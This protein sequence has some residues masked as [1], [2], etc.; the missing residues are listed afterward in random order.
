MDENYF[1]KVGQK[2]RHLRKVKGLSQ[3]E[4]GELLD[5]SSR[6]IQKYE[7]GEIE[8]S[9]SVVNKLAEILDSNPCYILGYDEPKPRPRSLGEALAFIFQL[10]E[11]EN[12]KMG[13][14]LDNSCG[15]SKV[16]LTFDGS[17]TSVECNAT[18][19][20]LLYHWN[21][22][23]AAC[24]EYMTTREF[25]DYWQQTQINDF[26]SLTLRYKTHEY[27]S[28]SELRKKRN[29]LLMNHPLNSDNG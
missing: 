13:L 6:T 10:D 22:E 9:V 7:T 28:Y 29:E 11:I 26:A 15:R 5:K 23:R 19:C 17:D 18:L 20:N 14:E 3:Q 27:L 8:V 4:L 25:Y 21:E 16:A 24:A 1:A 2:I 12:I